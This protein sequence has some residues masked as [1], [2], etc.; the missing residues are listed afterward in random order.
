MRNIRFSFQG[1]AQKK[2]GNEEEFSHV[3]RR[4][5]RVDFFAICSGFPYTT[6]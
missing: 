4:F 6:S 1:N 3:A 2:Q 5:L